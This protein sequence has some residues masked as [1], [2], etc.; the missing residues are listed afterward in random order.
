[1]TCAAVVQTRAPA[2]PVWPAAAAGSAGQRCAWRRFARSWSL[3]FAFVLG[4]EGE[5]WRRTYGLNSAF[6]AKQPPVCRRARAL[7]GE[8]AAVA[9]SGRGQPL[10]PCNRGVAYA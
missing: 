9:R 7:A 6:P 10:R 2:I 3:P 4:S 8:Q 5:V 1:P